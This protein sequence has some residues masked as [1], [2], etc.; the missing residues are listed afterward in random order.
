MAKAATRKTTTKK[1]T[2]KS[3][4]SK[5][6]VCPRCGMPVISAPKTHFTCGSSIQSGTFFKHCG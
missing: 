1:K 2:S 3:Q 5:P 6:E 4:S